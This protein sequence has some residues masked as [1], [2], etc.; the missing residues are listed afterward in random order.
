MAKE[1]GHPVIAV[2]QP[3][4][5]HGRPPKHPSGKRLSGSRGRGDRQP[6]AVRR[7]HTD[8]RRRTSPVGAVSSITA[9]SSPS[10]SPSAW[11]SA[12]ARV[13]RLPPL[14]LSAN[15]P[16][17]DEHNAE[18]ERSTRAASGAAPSHLTPGS[19]EQDPSHEIASNLEAHHMSITD[20]PLRR[21]DFLRGSLGLAALAATGSLAACAT[22]GTQP[23]TSASSSA[24]G[25]GQRHQPLRH[26]GQLDRRC[27]H[28]QRRLRHRLRRVRR[29]S[30]SRRLQPAAR[31][32]SRPPPRSRR[33][34]S[35]ASSPA[36]RRT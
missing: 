24:A 19:P 31:S 18:L 22:S 32:R 7:R 36:T 8:P 27:G 9:R 29:R 30:R 20:Q 12:C 34:C 5:H 14:Y 23:T 15:I 2:T 33:N 25:P 17:G 10:C 28:L 1:H 13:A 3:R 21:R 4:A 35:R 6:G 16:G 26:A 11:P